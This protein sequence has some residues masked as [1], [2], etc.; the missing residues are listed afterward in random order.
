MTNRTS[1]REFLG[2][3]AVAAA[4]SWAGASLCRRCLG[5]ARPQR[6]HQSGH[7]WLWRTVQE[8][9]PSFMKLPA[10]GHGRLRRPL[11]A[12]GRGPQNAAG[13]EKVRAYHDFRKLLEDKSID[14]VVVSTNAHWHVLCTI[15]ACQAGKDVYVEKPLGNFI[16]EGRFAVAAARKY[17]RIVQIGT[18]QRSRDHYRKAA[19]II[20]S[21]R[22]GEISEVKVWD[23]KT[24]PRAT[25]HRPT[26]I[27]PRNWTGI[28]TSGRRR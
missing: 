15:H 27:H 13:G 5:H 9:L 20:Q 14:A 23:C 6:Y 24:G 3:T 16:G 2:V 10:A 12:P 11:R 21:G 25:A 19:E 7:Y 18:Q 28:S 17:G 8:T 4:S 26:V 22:L 1:R